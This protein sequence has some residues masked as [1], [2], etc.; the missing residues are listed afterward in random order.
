M[1]DVALNLA[2]SLLAFILGL[3]ARR[4]WVAVTQRRPARVVWPFEPDDR[5]EIVMTT[6]PVEHAL[7]GSTLVY[8]AEAVAATEIES[9]LGRT[10]KV[11]GRLRVSDRFPSTK[12][13]RNLIV[14][15]GPVH[16]EVTR[17]LLDAIQPS[18][19]FD[20][21]AIVAP[22]GR[23]YEAT[24][25]FDPT[26][27]TKHDYGVVFRAP[28]PYLGASHVTLLMGSRTFGCLIAARAVLR[29][30]VREAAGRVSSGRSFGLVASAQVVDGEVQEVSIEES[31]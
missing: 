4:A 1:G 13:D 21:Y 17:R 10:L 11:S 3:G 6:A 30:N 2:S 23:R 25:G 20:G 31:W 7:E 28:N 22:S 26:Q 19:C 27:E 18:L 12:W 29:E 5:V 8:P 15:G 9:Y 14:V 16:N 24:S